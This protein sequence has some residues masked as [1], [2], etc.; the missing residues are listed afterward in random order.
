MFMIPHSVMSENQQV[1]YMNIADRTWRG[2]RL[3]APPV[4]MGGDGRVDNLTVDWD[5]R[6]LL[7]HSSDGFT[8]TPKRVLRA[9]NLATLSGTNPTDG[10]GG[11]RNLP[12]TAASGFSL[13]PVRTGYPSGLGPWNYEAL[14]VYY[15]P[16]GKYYRYTARLEIAGNNFP[17]G[18]AQGTFQTLERLTPPPYVGPPSSLPADY[19]L[20]QP[21]VFDEITLGTAMVRGGCWLASVRYPKR[22]KYVPTLQCLCWIPLD[23]GNTDPLTRNPVYLIKP[24]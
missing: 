3:G 6:L 20:T 12:L 19:Y 13:T 14:W 18:T 8:F 4:V 11:W 23:G 24:Y 16:N 5:R 7:F 2:L 9:F 15:P 22:L 17:I 1:N 10:T 21:W